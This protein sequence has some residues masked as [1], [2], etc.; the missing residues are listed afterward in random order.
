MFLAVVV[1]ACVLGGWS[2]TNPDRPVP[3][4]P[5]TCHPGDAPI[6]SAG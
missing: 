5:D 4:P 3:C 2:C 6:T 1:M